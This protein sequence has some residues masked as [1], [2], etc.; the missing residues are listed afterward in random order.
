LLLLMHRLYK[1]IK[2]IIFMNIVVTLM[3]ALCSLSRVSF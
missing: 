2:D 3:Y 1:K